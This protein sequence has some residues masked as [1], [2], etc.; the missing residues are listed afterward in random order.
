MSVRRGSLQCFTNKRQNANTQYAVCERYG[1]RLKRGT[2]TINLFVL[3]LQLT[4]IKLSE[5]RI[6]FINS[7]LR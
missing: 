4:Y 6:S 5:N 2:V 1:T 3:P 7:Y